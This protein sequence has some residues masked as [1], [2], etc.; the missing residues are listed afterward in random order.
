MRSFNT[1]KHSQWKD[2]LDI[3]EIEFDRYKKRI[4]NLT[5]FEQKLNIRASDNPFEQKKEYYSQSDFRMTREICEY[6]RWSSEVIEQRCLE[7]AETA[8]NIWNF[9]RI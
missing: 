9:D 7:M 1:Q 8:L 3:S 5:L 6:S 2:Y 4:G